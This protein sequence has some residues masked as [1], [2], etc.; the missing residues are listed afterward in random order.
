MERHN[1]T[2]RIEPLLIAML[3]MKSFQIKRRVDRKDK[4][5]AYLWSDTVPYTSVKVFRI[6]PAEFP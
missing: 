5:P 3:S 6:N 1:E 2:A 4:I